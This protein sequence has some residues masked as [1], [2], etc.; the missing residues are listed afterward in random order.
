MTTAL[1]EE[2]VTFRRRLD[3]EA[4]PRPDARDQDVPRD[5][6]LVREDLVPERLEGRAVDR[7]T[8][9]ERVVA[10]LAR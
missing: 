10:L 9:R 8:P 3:G 5:V 4:A 2:R 1:V 7:L 6:R